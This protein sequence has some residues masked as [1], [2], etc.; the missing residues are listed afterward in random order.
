MKFSINKQILK[1]VD[2]TRVVS[3]TVKYLEASFSFSDDW[4]DLTKLACFQKGENIYEI[5]LAFDSDTGDYVITAG[6]GLNLS[7]GTWTISVVGVSV[8]DSVLDKR[9]TTYPTTIT[10][11][12]AGALGGD[13]FPEIGGAVGE[14]ILQSEEDR[15]IAED[16]RAAAEEEREAW[17]ENIQ[18]GIDKTIT[19]L[20]ANGTTTHVL[21]FTN[22]VLTACTTV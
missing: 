20:D 22:G 6:D 19:V 8:T 5:E 21:V 10:I 4:A 9:I 1:R 17:F 3:D 16:A 12:Q 2:A 15:I 18:T 11:L 13:A 7:S 14:Q